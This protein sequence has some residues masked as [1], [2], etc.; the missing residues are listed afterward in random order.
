[1][2]PGTSL[3]VEGDVLHIHHRFRPTYVST[4]IEQDY[5]D[6]QSAGV[7]FLVA[8]STVF[9]QAFAAPDDHPDAYAAYRRLFDR[10][11]SPIIISPTAERSGPEIRIYQLTE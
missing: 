8:S 2:P 9:G 5:D 1:M 4:L 3:A 10:A 7:T 11:I 6:Y